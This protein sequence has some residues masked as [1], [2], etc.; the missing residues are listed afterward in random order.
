MKTI[1]DATWHEIPIGDSQEHTACSKGIKAGHEFRLQSV[2]GLHS[3]SCL[4]DDARTHQKKVSDL[5]PV[6]T[7]SLNPL[8]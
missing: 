4:P 8:C 2:M 7:I 5:P 3:V 6:E 1:W